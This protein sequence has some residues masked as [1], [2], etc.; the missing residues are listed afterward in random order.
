MTEFEQLRDLATQIKKQRKTNL[1][2]EEF[3]LATELAA[4]VLKDSTSD[5]TA[6]LDT[7]DFF[8]AP[9]I[10][11]TAKRTWEEMPAQ[12]KSIFVRWI[13][14][15]EGDRAP[16]R[17]LYSASRIMESDPATAVE[18][19][20][21][22]LPR[23]ENLSQEMKAD[24]RRA[25]GTKRSPNLALLT[26][27]QLNQEVI[28]RFCRSMLQSLDTQTP[29]PN[30][31]ALVKVAVDV[32]ARRHPGDP[33]FLTIVSGIAAHLRS[34]P[35][36]A[37]SEFAKYVSSTTPALIQQLGLQNAATPE[38]DTNLESS[39][40]IE[41]QVNH[42]KNSSGVQLAP[43]ASWLS[44]QIRST[45]LQL[46]ALLGFE[47]ILQDISSREE[48]EK[49]V[50]TLE[51]ELR[52]Q[53]ELLAEERAQTSELRQKL[54]NV[55]H[56]TQQLETEATERMAEL[57]RNRA[58]NNRLSS[59]ITANANAVVEEF[60]NRLG[61]TLAKLVVDLPERGMEIDFE[62]SR[63]LLRQYH[64]FIDKLEE[65]GIIVRGRRT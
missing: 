50:D 55:R 53:L 21:A 5:L 32:A 31:Q 57:D 1:P 28:A 49:R 18:F 17:I 30:K 60:K 37:R 44:Q 16:K 62:R 61:A 26:S 47:Q 14:R 51:R 9:L 48:L 54:E 58:E 2:E 33:I 36:D 12:R 11:E 56:K 24:L 41:E 15:R 59:Q 35:T 39:A 3:R 6:V 45:K 19:L 22:V 34:W 8:P 20:N 29:F 46:D 43:V 27:P 52:Q 23:D 10:A 25:F 38:Q 40:V 65:S 63:F 42:G 13:T 4:A 64:Q 7:L